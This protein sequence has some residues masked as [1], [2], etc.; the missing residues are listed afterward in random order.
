MTE[1]F[2]LDISTVNRYREDET[3]QRTK[4]YAEAS[5]R[6]AIVAA[7]IAAGQ[8]G[9]GQVKGLL[10]SKVPILISPRNLKFL[11]NCVD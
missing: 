7:G 1:Y 8:I 3:F 6:A 5:S 4:V 10:E 9:E 11:E 2:W